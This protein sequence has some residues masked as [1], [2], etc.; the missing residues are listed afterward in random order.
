MWS[1]LSRGFASRR[2]KK[3]KIV[4]RDEYDLKTAVDLIKAGS[5][6]GKDESVDVLVKSARVTQTRHRP[7]QGRPDGPRH[8]SL[9]AQQ[10]QEERDPLR[11][12]QRRQQAHRAAERRRLGGRQGHH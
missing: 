12:H 1:V 10:R 7:A 4:E 5:I 3:V 6:S 2:V 11:L 8:L 9:P